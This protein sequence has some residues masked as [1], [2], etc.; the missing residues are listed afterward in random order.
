[1]VRQ[2]LACWTV[3]YHPQARACPVSA[4]RPSRAATTQDPAGATR[5]TPRCS[6]LCPF[7]LRTPNLEETRSKRRTS[8]GKKSHGLRVA[9][10]LAAGLVEGARALAPCPGR[11][12]G[13]GGAGGAGRHPGREKN[14]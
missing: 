9:F 6:S 10:A 7:I 3:T 14:P 1:M 8:M 12:G 2:E 11:G 13:G 4:T 5:S